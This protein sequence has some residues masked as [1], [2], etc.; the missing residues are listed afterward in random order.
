MLSEN[1]RSQKQLARKQSGALDAG[2][3]NGQGN[4]MTAFPQWNERHMRRQI[5]EV[6]RRLYQHFF[7]A[8]NDGNISVRL[9]E[10]EILITPASVSKADL[11]PAMLVKITPEGEQI[12]PADGA[13][14]SSESRM[15]LAIYRERPDIRAVVHA[16]PPTAT[17]FAVANIGLEE[18]F[19][20]EV[21]VRTG[22]TPVVPYTIP[23]GDELPQSMIPYLQDHVTLLLGNHG[24]VAYGPTLRDAMFNMETIELNARIYLTA[25]QLGNIRFLDDAEVEALRKRYNGG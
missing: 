14:A 6:G 25:R 7:V 24:V 3:Q 5:C 1:K 13:H 8:A 15:H 22:A 12:S 21:V 17:G 9:N 4:G 2:W 10:R 18:P 23:G 20:P 16:H 19:L 11:T